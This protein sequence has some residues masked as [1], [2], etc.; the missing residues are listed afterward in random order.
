MATNIEKSW[1]RE[2][3]F[4]S[5]IPK[6]GGGGMPK[7]G[8]EQGIDG[9]DYDDDDDGDSDSEEDNSNDGDN[10]DEGG[11]GDDGDSDKDGNKNKKH[12]LN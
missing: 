4:V 3:R 7:R 6:F 9:D 10:G 2:H 8:Q 12:W 5:K 11:D 1:K